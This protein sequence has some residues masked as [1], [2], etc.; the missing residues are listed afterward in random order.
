MKSFLSQTAMRST[1]S[2]TAS[3]HAK[4]ASQST[5]GS[6]KTAEQGSLLCNR[7]I[8]DLINDQH[9]INLTFPFDILIIHVLSYNRPEINNIVKV[10]C[11][12]FIIAYL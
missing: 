6:I 5:P 11:L 7:K 8:I 12:K 2:T 10:I 4:H 9:S 3:P 1:V